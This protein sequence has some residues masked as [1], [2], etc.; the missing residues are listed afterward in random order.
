VIELALATDTAPRDW[1]DEDPRTIATAAA[2][3]KRR[4]AQQRQANR[5]RR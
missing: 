5:A 3:L 2:I 4:A 1:W